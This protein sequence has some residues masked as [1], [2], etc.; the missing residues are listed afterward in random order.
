MKQL[1]AKEF[2]LFIS[3]SLTSLNIFYP[4]ENGLLDGDAL[5]L[6]QLMFKLLPLIIDLSVIPEDESF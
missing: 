3:S 4:S 5:K 1:N 2:D 6:R